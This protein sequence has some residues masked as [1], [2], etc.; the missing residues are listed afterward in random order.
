ML[1]DV[2]V[3]LALAWPSHQFH[4]RARI[5]FQKHQ[6][7]PWF[8]CAITQLGFVRISS[9]QAFTKHAKRP[10]EAQALLN[11]TT[12][13]RSHQY[14][15]EL[16]ALE[17]FDMLWNHTLGHKQTTDIYLATIAA[18]HKTRLC[19]FDIRLLKHPVVGSYIVSPPV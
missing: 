15:A 12:A 7:E 16:P 2:N 1:L 10:G 3:L 9:N 14:L 4:H 17:H 5:W 6:D 8:T 19:S 11:Q 18:H 13:H